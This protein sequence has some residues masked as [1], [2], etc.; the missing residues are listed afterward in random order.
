L[1]WACLSVLAHDSEH[2]EGQ[3]KLQKSQALALCFLALARRELPVEGV[4]P[5]NETLDRE[6]MRCLE[7][8]CLLLHRCLGGFNISQF[9]EL[10]EVQR[11]AGR[12]VYAFPEL[13][14]LQRCVDNRA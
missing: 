4:G 3:E 8:S 5:R 14:S 6:V 12:L 7:A 11:H 10:I 2:D 13:R 1:R 9:P